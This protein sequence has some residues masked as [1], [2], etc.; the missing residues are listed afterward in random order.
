M[1]LSD[2]LNFS[3]RFSRACAC[4]AFL[5]FSFLIIF[6]VPYAREFQAYIAVSYGRE[7]FLFK[8]NDLFIFFGNFVTYILFII[9]LN[10]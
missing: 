3:G 8:L 1:L 9:F 2:V 4:C 5:L 6:C 7:F 10:G